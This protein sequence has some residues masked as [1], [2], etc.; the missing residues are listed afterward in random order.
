MPALFHLW[1]YLRKRAP[2]G[3]AVS[4]AQFGAALPSLA[5]TIPTQSRSHFLFG[6]G[7]RPDLMSHLRKPWLTLH[8]M[9][10]DGILNFFVLSGPAPA[11]NAG[12]ATSATTRMS[13]RT[14]PADLRI[15]L[16]FGM[17]TQ[18]KAQR[19]PLFPNR[20][21]DVIAILHW[22]GFARCRV[23]AADGNARHACRRA[24]G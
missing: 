4:P 23:E 16:I 21:N 5:M 19:K 24:L 7:L 15:N 12:A 2:W 20:V 1:P 18:P 17:M 8:P 3:K 6:S 9:F 10:F 14:M 11:W 13:A 22:V